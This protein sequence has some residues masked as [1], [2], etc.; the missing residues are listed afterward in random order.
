MKC[1]YKESCGYDFCLEED[2]PDYEATQETNADRIRAMSADEL[3][4]LLTIELTVAAP[5]KLFVSP[6][7][8]GQ[9]LSKKLAKEEM[10]EWLQ[11]PA[12]EE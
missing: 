6:P 5:C 8:G 4:D 9:Y 2:C 3:A 11:Q 12:E 7:T 10:L 1:K